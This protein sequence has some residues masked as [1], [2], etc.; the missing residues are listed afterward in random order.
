MI[1]KC[2]AKDNISSS[3]CPLHKDKYEFKSAR[4]EYGSPGSPGR[5][6]YLEGGG[7][8]P[9]CGPP[10]GSCPERADCPPPPPQ[11]YVQTQVHQTGAGQSPPEAAAPAEPGPPPGPGRQVPRAPLTG[12]T[13]VFQPAAPRPRAPC[14]G[15]FVLSCHGLSGPREHSAQPSEKQ[16]PEKTKP[17][18]L[19]SLPISCYLISMLQSEVNRT[20]NLL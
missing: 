9:G 7:P 2:T 3:L 20:R 6:R 1:Q 19:L 8:R 12:L 11:E 10:P 16:K 5:S 15:P 17:R 13:P 14:P 18:L 4:P